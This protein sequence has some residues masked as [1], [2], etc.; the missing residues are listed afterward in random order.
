MSPTKPDR[1]RTVSPPKPDRSRTVSPPKPDRSRK[2][3]KSPRVKQE[4]KQE[5]TES[6]VKVEDSVK[7]DSDDDLNEIKSPQKKKFHLENITKLEKD[8]VD[9]KLLVEEAQQ[10]DSDPQ[11]EGEQGEHG[12]LELGQAEHQSSYDLVQPDHLPHPPLEE[13]KD[14][15]YLSRLQAIAAAIS[16]PRADPE[17]LNTIVNIILETGNFGTSNDSFNFDLCNLDKQSIQK[18]SISLKLEQPGQV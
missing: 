8:T 10:Q 11:P 14:T 12:P 2:T 18:I 16:D 7:K 17:T 6:K 3:V 9:E 4:L 1:S 5:M 13:V 15:K